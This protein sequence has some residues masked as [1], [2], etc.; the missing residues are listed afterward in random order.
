MRSDAWCVKVKMEKEEEIVENL[1]L[2]TRLSVLEKK[3]GTKVNRVQT[4]I[5]AKRTKMAS[6]EEANTNTI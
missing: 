3:K 4:C 5:T 6:R 1:G 2:P